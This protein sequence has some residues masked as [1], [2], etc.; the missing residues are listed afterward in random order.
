MQLTSSSVQ[1]TVAFLVRLCYFL[2]LS[3]SNRGCL[4]PP[5]VLSLILASTTSTINTMTATRACL[6]ILPPLMIHHDRVFRHGK[7]G[8]NN[9]VLAVLGADVMHLC[10]ADLLLSAGGE[11]F[12][13]KLTKGLLSVR[14]PLATNVLFSKLNTT[15][16]L[17]RRLAPTLLNPRHSLEFRSC[18]VCRRSYI[19]HQSTETLFSQV[20]MHRQRYFRHTSERS[21]KN[22]D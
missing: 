7:V 14:T 5:P 13:M 21:T 11:G 6:P 22:M 10:I 8:D 4:F 18:T 20:S 3:L 17:L 15:T 19:V 16:L 9:H 12:N 2:S 1:L